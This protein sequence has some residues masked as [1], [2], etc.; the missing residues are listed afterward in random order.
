[1]N[2]VPKLL[3]EYFF[4][5]NSELCRRVAEVFELKITNIKNEIFCKLI[6]KL[7]KKTESIK[8]ATKNEIDRLIE[9]IN[10]LEKNQALKCEEIRIQ[11]ANFHNRENDLVKKLENDIITLKEEVKKKKT[12]K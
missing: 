4:C 12:G 8:L 2:L 7:C 10:N 6:E 9:K 5:G 1:M 3:E 11:M